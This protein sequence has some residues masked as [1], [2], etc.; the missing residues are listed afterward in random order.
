MK[1]VLSLVLS[2]TLLMSISSN[3]FAAVEQPEERQSLDTENIRIADEVEIKSLPEMTIDKL[4]KA[5][6]LSDSAETKLSNADLSTGTALTDQSDLTD[7]KQSNQSKANTF[8]TTGVTQ[9]WTGTLANQGDFTYIIVT[10]ALN[11]Y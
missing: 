7:G 8:S 2:F 3:A 6:D 11:K 5:S 9:S 4:V 1:K 10:L